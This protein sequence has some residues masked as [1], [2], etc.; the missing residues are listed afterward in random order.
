MSFCYYSCL[1]LM[2][3]ISFSI[4]SLYSVIVFLISSYCSFVFS[5]FVLDSFFRFCKLVSI[6]FSDELQKFTYCSSTTWISLMLASVYCVLISLLFIPVIDSFICS[7]SVLW[8]VAAV[9]SWYFIV[10]IV[11]CI[12]V[13]IAFLIVFMWYTALSLSKFIWWYRLALNWI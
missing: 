5:L 8:I 11:F 9:S 13:Y 7:C 3:F 10:I 4:L 2:Y 1:S 6:V 12:R